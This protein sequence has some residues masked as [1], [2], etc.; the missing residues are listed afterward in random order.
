MRSQ[1]RNESRSL[2]A[3][4]L[5]GE[6]VMITLEI[7]KKVKGFLEA[8]CCYP[9]AGLAAAEGRYR[10]LYFRVAILASVSSSTDKPC[11]LDLNQSLFLLL[12]STST[13]A[14]N[15]ASRSEC[16]L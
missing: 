3:D 2:W 12:P 6:G 13:F 8:H 4:P 14:S 10:Y 7:V 9:F 1:K 5:F 15:L 16:N 11:P